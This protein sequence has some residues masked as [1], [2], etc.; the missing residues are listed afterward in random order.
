MT[1]AAAERPW[2][3]RGLSNASPSEVRAALTP[4]DA[5]DFDE[6]WRVAMAQATRDLD[7]TE[8]HSML[9]SWR[10]AAILTTHLGHAGYRRMMNSAEY[11]L[12][13]G[14]R[15]EGST[16]WLDLKVQLGL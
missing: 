3:P 7:L 14:E 9:D 1:A 15:A 12:R 8:V 10:R 5:A 4:E 6:Q 11:R 16:P 2:E 13:T